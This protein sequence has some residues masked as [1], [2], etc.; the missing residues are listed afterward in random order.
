MEP[1]KNRIL[2]IKTK[3]GSR[4][5]AGHYNNIT[6]INIMIENCYYCGWDNA[7]D[8]CENVVECYRNYILYGRHILI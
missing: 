5:S 1:I 3:Q 2:I 7:D 4:Y 8:D 6:E